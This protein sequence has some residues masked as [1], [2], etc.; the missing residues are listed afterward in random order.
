MSKR[1]KPKG[2]G[3]QPTNQA[4]NLKPQK[5]DELPVTNTGRKAKRLFQIH[6][7][8]GSKRV[9][10]APDFKLKTWEKY[11]KDNNISISVKPFP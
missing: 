3:Q 7:H 4:S 1:E 10:I 2:F 5:T 9:I 11:A 6:F 8:D